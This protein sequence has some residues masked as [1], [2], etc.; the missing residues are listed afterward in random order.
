MAL[1]RMNVKGFDVGLEILV[2]LALVRKLTML[3]KVVD[4]VHSRKN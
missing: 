3:P 2:A 1:S 4:R